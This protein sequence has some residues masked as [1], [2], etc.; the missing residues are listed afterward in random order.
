MQYAGRVSNMNLVYGLALL[1]FSAAQ[2]DRAPA[3]Y[4]GGHRFECCWGRLRFFSLPHAT[5]MLIN[6]FSH[7]LEV[8]VTEILWKLEIRFKTDLRKIYENPDRGMGDRISL[9]S[10]G[11]SFVL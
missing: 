8:V 6:S 3:R 1:E 11:A 9:S 2:V 5:D 10:A 7:K 4:L